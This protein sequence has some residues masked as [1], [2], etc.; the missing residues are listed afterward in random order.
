MAPLVKTFHKAPKDKIGEYNLDANDSFVLAAELE[1]GAIG[2]IQATRFATGYANELYVSLFGDKGAVRV[3]TDGKVSSLKLCAGADIDTNTWRDVDCPEVPT[4]YQRFARAVASGK[5][6]D[7][8][9]RRAADIQR[10]LDLILA[11]G[12][13]AGV[14][15]AKARRR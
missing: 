12:N 7:P 9:F 8:N 3:H 4:T 10:V 14:K 15:V 5:N 6:G 13:G 2:T 11:E 1:N